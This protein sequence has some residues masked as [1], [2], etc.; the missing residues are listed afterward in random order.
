MSKQRRETYHVTGILPQVAASSPVPRLTQLSQLGAS[1][2]ASTPQMNVFAPD[3]QTPISMPPN[4]AQTTPAVCEV[5]NCGVLAE[6]RCVFC[7]HP[8]CKMHQARFLGRIYTDTYAPCFPKTEE[9]KQQCEVDNCGNTA[10]DHCG[11]CKRAI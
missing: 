2:A 9:G 5:D 4:E 6:G 11:T 10:V 8:F 1:P 7:G 3:L